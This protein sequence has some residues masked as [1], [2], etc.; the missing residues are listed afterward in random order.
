MCKLS[1]FCKFS[2]RNPDHHDSVSGIRRFT[3]NS[4]YCLANLQSFY[5]IT[6]ARIYSRN[7]PPQDDLSKVY[8]LAK[9]GCTVGVCASRCTGA[10]CNLHTMLELGTSQS[11]HRAGRKFGTQIHEVSDFF[12]F[13]LYHCY[14]E[15]A[16]RSPWTWTRMIHARRC[17]SLSILAGKL[18]VPSVSLVPCKWDSLSNY[19][20][21]G[22]HE[23]LRSRTACVRL[24]LWR[25]KCLR[26]HL[27]LYKQ[28][29]GRDRQ[30]RKQG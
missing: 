18:I 30:P 7:Q 28:L 3:T 26:E 22:V 20:S 17:R 19:I 23:I 27:T 14:T 29:F 24:D 8:E 15:H 4:N 10:V 5:P 25:K 9:T 16:W 1:V 12:H 13:G 21:S 2:G 11:L 6:G